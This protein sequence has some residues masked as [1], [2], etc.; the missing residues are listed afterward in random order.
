MKNDFTTTKLS[1][2]NSELSQLFS[3][4]NSNNSNSQNMISTNSNSV[5]NEECDLNLITIK[6]LNHSN[7][8]LTPMSQ[9]K[10]SKC[11]FLVNNSH[12]KHKH[13][14]L[15]LPKAPTSTS[16]NLSMNVTTSL[17]SMTEIRS[18]IESVHFD[19]EDMLKYKDDVFIK[20]NVPKAN[21]TN[22]LKLDMI[23]LKESYNNVM[24]KNK[25][26][27]FKKSQIER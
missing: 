8:T 22:T 7:T 4:S 16:M 26:M 11:E 27:K 21:H 24:N 14:V 1:N 3:H 5:D 13:S 18:C 12:I 17:D 6:G 25:K 15:N 19:E 10:N 2:Y 9:N 23:D 20:L